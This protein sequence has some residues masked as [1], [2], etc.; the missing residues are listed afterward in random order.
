MYVQTLKQD[1]Y[2]MRK[3][4]KQK[5]QQQQKKNNPMHTASESIK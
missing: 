4:L 2:Y 3:Y 5:E 1:N